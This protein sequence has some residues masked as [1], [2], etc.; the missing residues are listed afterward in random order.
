MSARSLPGIVLFLLALTGCGRAVAPGLEGQPSGP[1]TLTLDLDTPPVPGRPNTLVFSLTRTENR[2]PVSDL[3]I[4]HERALHT[5][6]VARDFSSFAHIHQEDFGPLTAQDLAA[7]RFTFP[8]AFPRAGQYR[9]VNEF[10][11]HDRTWRKQFNVTVGAPAAIPQVNI[12]LGRA[13]IVQGYQASLALSPPRA[14]AGA[15]AE[16]VLTLTHAGEPVTNLELLLGAEVHV[17]LWRIDG[18]YFGHAH[19][20][21]PEMVA[22]MRAM[23][24]HSAA[25]SEAMML[26]MM[27]A[28]A[29]LVYPGPR[30][31]I[32]ITFPEPG[33]Y[34][35]FIQCAPGGKPLVFPF[36]IE[37]AP[38]H[39][40]LDTKL[41][42][43][44]PDA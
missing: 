4:I 15:E 20:Y 19:S 14:V 16:L 34:Q 30:I 35:L 31:P 43:I 26:K 9:I 44:V 18:E 24:G 22:M 11:H 32:R 25:H 10:T 21:T 13:R 1:Y 17:A 42:S 6:I 40:G 3:Q 23:A 38:D 29:R 2:K 36:M 27:A 39:Q 5:F 41:E 12:D 37:V 8:Y 33:F 7:A 28:P